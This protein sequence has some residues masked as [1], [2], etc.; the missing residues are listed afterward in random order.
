VSVLVIVEL[1]EGDVQFIPSSA[2]DAAREF[3][4]HLRVDRASR[5]AAPTPHRE[6]PIAVGQSPSAHPALVNHGCEHALGGD[7]VAACPAS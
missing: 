2:K 3:P 7:G 5:R 1:T 4:T 6:A